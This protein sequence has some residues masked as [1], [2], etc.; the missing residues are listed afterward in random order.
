MPMIDLNTPLNETMTELAELWRAYIYE[1][2]NVQP[3]A[4]ATL[5]AKIAKGSTYP[6][7][8]LIDTEATIN[9]IG[10]GIEQVS[11]NEIR[12]WVTIQDPELAAIA[13]LHEYG[14]GPPE[15]PILRPVCDINMDRLLDKLFDSIGSQLEN[16]FN[17]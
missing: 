11:E 9:S 4:P 10:S 1:G 8:P 17:K 7:I 16:E 2:T 5:A 13:C 14:L 12:G 6:D 3:L 15:R